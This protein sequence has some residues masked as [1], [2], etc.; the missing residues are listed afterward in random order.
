MGLQSVSNLPIYQN[1]GDRSIYPIKTSIS[2]DEIVRLIN[3]DENFIPRQRSEGEKLIIET[4]EHPNTAGNYRITKDADTLAYISYNYKREE[5]DLSYHK[6]DKTKSFTSIDAYF[7]YQT[8]KNDIV[9]LWKWL[10]IF[11]L[12]MLIT[13]VLI[14]KY[15]K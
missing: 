3:E 11:A 10:L 5:S 6:V 15:I 13:E 1:I 4:R 8:S 9:E 12:T 7:E 14:Q 2:D